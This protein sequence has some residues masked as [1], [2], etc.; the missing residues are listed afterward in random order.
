MKIDLSA[1]VGEGADDL[2]LFPVL[3]S[4]SVACGA[5]AGDETTMQRCVEEAKRLGIDI[6]AHPG[7]PDR[8]GFGRRVIPMQAGE[9]RDTLVAQIGTLRVVCTRNDAR[10]THVKPHGALYNQAADDFALAGTIA[11]AIRDAGEDL[12][13]VG[14]AGSRMLEAGSEA[15]V[16]IV[17]EA[18]ADRR[19]MAGG[20]LAPRSLE[21]SVIDDPAEAAAQAVALATGQVIKDIHGGPLLIEAETICLHSDTPG[22]LDIARAVRAALER[23]GV[24]VAPLHSR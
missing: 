10:L 19:Y 20:R 21:G 14:L 16:A 4:V 11:E 8:E 2:P 24:R 5:H 12:A 18:F 7:Y 15:G 22:A 1:D 23:A 6:G 17:A 13:I 3:T 9:L